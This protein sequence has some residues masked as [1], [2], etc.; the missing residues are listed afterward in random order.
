MSLDQIIINLLKLQAEGHGDKEVYYRRGSSGDCGVL[1]YASV[2]NEVDN[3]CGPFDLSPGEEYI[4]ISAG[5]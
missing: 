2:T 5:N 1:S 4:Q 3:E